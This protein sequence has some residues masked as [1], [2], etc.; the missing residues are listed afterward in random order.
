MAQF[1]KSAISIYAVKTIIGQEKALVTFVEKDE[2]I[3]SILVPESLKG[4]VFVEAE[5]QQIV[6]QSISVVPQLH[7]RVIGKVSNDEIEHFLA[8]KKPTEGLKKDDIV[9]ILDGPFKGEQARVTKVDPNKDEVRLEL[10][11]SSQQDGNVIPI[12]IHADFI[13]RIHAAEEFLDEEP[14]QVFEE[15]PESIK[16]IEEKPLKKKS[17]LSLE[18]E[19][20]EE[21][22]SRIGMFDSTEFEE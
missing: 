9:E 19:E 12:K 14:V 16:E 2:D 11:S 18:E 10:F 13:K 6:N 17:K 3:I 4:Y 8:S 21:E 15:E 20:E 7:A 22:E 5:E 1:Q